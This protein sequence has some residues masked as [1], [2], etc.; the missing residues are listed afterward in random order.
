MARNKKRSKF[1]VLIIIFLAMIIVGIGVGYA[2]LRASVI[3]QFG[4][5]A[6][7][8]TLTQ[9]I[10][11]PFELFIY[12]QQLISPLDIGGIE[13]SFEISQGESIGMVCLRLEQ[14]GLIKNAELMRTYLVYSGKDRLLQAG[15]F[16]L[17]P[18]MPPVQIG[19]ELLDASLKQAIINIL[20]GWRIEEV[21][22][23]VAGSGLAISA[24]EFIATAYAPTPSHVAILPVSEIT[25]LEGFLFPGTYEFPREAD[26][27][28][29][30]RTILSAFTENVDQKLRDG[31]DQQGLSLE[32]SVTLAS[33]VEKEAVVTEEKPMIASVFYNRLAQG[34]RLETDPTVQYALGFQ[35]GTQSWWKSP[36]SKADLS[37]NS[38]YNTYVVSGIP[39]TSICNPGMDSLQAV[40]YPAQ[41][42]YYYFRS[43]CDESGRH[44]FAITFEEHLNNACE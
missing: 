36:L 32:E 4:E 11:Y 15:S 43:A 19:E 5:P 10:L 3:T 26:L 24:E 31:F 8:L 1:F 33:I 9:R 12:R 25:T 28:D 44:N 20:P 18:S 34:M 7:Y 30:L 2:I 35:D 14:A 37:I 17:S 13:Q 16:N 27:D 23:N 6:P 38:P 39:P 40:A 22:L 21:A 41:T 29:V 42:P